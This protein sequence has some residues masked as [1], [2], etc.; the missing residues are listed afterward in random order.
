MNYN[1]IRSIKRLE[2]IEEKIL[3]AL[4]SPVIVYFGQTYESIRENQRKNL[5]I[6]QD[7]IKA[8]QE[9]KKVV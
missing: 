2:Q 6:V 4:H 9:K 5:K 7:R 3:N 8:L 1:K